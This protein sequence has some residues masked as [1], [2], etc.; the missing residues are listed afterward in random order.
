MVQ[1]E[2]GQQTLY[3]RSQIDIINQLWGA[4]EMT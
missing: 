2:P 1:T 3:A 4:L